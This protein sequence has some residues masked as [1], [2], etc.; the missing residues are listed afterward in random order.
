MPH[1]LVKKLEA[2]PRMRK[3]RKRRKQ[4]SEDSAISSVNGKR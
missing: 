1:Q 3:K 2:K 4:G